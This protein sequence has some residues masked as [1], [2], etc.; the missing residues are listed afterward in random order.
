LQEQRLIACVKQGRYR[1]F[2]L[3]GQPVADVLETLMA[4]A[5]VERPTV[6][7]TTPPRCNSP[8]PATIIWPVKWR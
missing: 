1:Y 4:L 7:S 3:A 2:R 8:A 5:G 6:K